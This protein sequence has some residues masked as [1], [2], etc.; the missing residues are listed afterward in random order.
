MRTIRAAAGQMIAH[1]LAQREGVWAVM[2]RLA[3]Q[4][5]QEQVDLLVLP[6]CTYPAYWLESAATYRAT[7]RLPHARTLERLSALAAESRLYLV[8]GFVEEAGDRLY[9]SAA[10]IDAGGRL[11]GVARKTFLWDCDNRWFTPGDRISV[12]DTPLGRLGVQICAD[13]RAPETTATLAAGGAEL[14]AMPTAWVNGSKAPGQA[15]NIQPD[16]LIESRAREFGLPFVCAD[17]AGP[18]GPM[19]YVGQSLIVGADG[20]VLRRAAPTGEALMIADI[21]PARGRPAALTNAQR[22]RL[23]AA[24]REYPPT[25]EHGTLRVG[26]DGF[27]AGSARSVIV[28]G[29]AA[30]SFVEIRIHALAGAQAVCVRDA[31]DDLATLRARAAENRVFVLARSPAWCVII[32]PDG[33]LLRTAPPDNVAVCEVCLGDADLKRFTPETDLW[34]QRRTPCYRFA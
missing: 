8:C 3:R 26:V 33:A 32:A 4:A 20:C 19:H 21:V 1:T 15:W 14:V 34:T 7:D 27:D 28:D 24:P 10:V 13:A 11:I 16:F 9:N 29:Q 25:A 2:E 17:K 31:D 5:R 12:F 22:Q 23:L 6:E 30:R 18:E